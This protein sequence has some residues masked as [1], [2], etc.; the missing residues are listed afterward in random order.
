MHDLNLNLFYKTTFDI[1]TIDPCNDVLWVLVLNI[2]SWICTKW[3][4]NGVIISTEQRK[5]SKFKS[6]F[7]AD[8]DDSDRVVHLESAAFWKTSESGEWACSISEMMADPPFAHREW[9][10]EIGFVE[11]AHNRGKLSMVLSY[12]DRPGFLGPVHEAPGASIPNIIRMLRND[13]R[14]RCTVSGRSLPDGPIELRVGDFP[15]FWSFVSDNVRDVPIILL[16]SRFDSDGRASL[17]VDPNVLVDML[18]PSAFVYYS[19]DQNFSAEMSYYLEDT[20]LRCTN[21]AL[22]VYAPHPKFSDKGDYG[23]HRYFTID[24]IKRF[25]QDGMATILRRALAQD[26]NFYEGMVRVNT[27]REKCRFR[28]VQSAAQREIDNS[29]SAAIDLVDEAEVRL[30]ECAEERDRAKQECQEIRETI[31]ILNSKN[32]ALENALAERSDTNADVKLSPWPLASSEIAELFL[33]AYPA[34]IDFTERGWKS[35]DDCTTAPDILWNAFHDLCTVMYDLCANKT[36]ID[37]KRVFNNRSRFTYAQ[38]AGMMTR[39]DNNLMSEYMDTYQGRELNCEGHIKSGGKESD[40][41]FIRIYFAFDRD[42]KKIIISSC[43][44]HLK[45]YS[46]KNIH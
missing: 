19:T 44:K 21:G 31:H 30:A 14:I 4:R 37:V 8:L 38:G 13:E 11:E 7:A 28:R 40:P 18:G 32:D 45:N 36:G 33:A 27:I 34:R 1:E 29:E 20:S 35:L 25:G 26:V 39:K 46:S 2:K 23:R 9:K 22:R 12:G 42:S 24:D 6:G 17:S 15:E 41:K 16:S 43:G 3:R 10:T 5:W